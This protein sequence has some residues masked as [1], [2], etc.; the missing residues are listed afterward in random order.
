LDVENYTA[1]KYEF[2][3]TEVVFEKTADSKTASLKL[4]LPGCYGGEI[5]GKLP[6]QK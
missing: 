3:I 6:W 5:A 4:A 1:K 2:L